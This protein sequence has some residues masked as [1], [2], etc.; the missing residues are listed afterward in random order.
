MVHNSY[1]QGR[2]GV[3]LFWGFAAEVT[4]LV[5]RVWRSAWAAEAI[6]ELSDA[7]VTA[8]DLAKGAPPAL[9]VGD[10]DARGEPCGLGRSCNVWGSV[11]GLGESSL[12]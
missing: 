8:Q 1:G 6:A 3:T 11:L 10:H 5:A 4:N 9:R 7:A 12:G 2:S